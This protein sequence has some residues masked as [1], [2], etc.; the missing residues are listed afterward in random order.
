MRISGSV[1]IG[2]IVWS[3]ATNKI[4]FSYQDF[5]N[6][7]GTRREIEEGEGMCHNMCIELGLRVIR[8]STMTSCYAIRIKR[9]SLGTCVESV[10]ITCHD[11]TSR[12]IKRIKCDGK[13]MLEICIQGFFF[14][15]IRVQLVETFTL[16]DGAVDCTINTM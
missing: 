15:E 2:A 4:L 5:V 9:I 13:E 11:L 16:V 6:Q 14:Q 8:I 1:Y 3:C 12:H 7:L 10:E